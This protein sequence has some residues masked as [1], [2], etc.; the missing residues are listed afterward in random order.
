MI[1]NTLLALLLALTL[2]AGQVRTVLYNKPAQTAVSC[3]GTD[4]TLGTYTI[5][6][7]TMS[8][9][10]TLDVVATARKVTGPAIPTVRLWFGA[11]YG[12]GATATTGIASNA[13][14]LG[15]QD[16]AQTWV[17]AT[18]GNRSTVGSST[19][20]SPAPKEA[21]SGNIVT[22]LV[23]DGGSCA[24]GSTVQ[25]AR[26]SVIDVRNTGVNAPPADF[27]L[28]SIPVNIAAQPGGMGSYVVTVAPLN[29]FTATATL[30][31]TGWPATTSYSFTPTTITGGSGSSTLAFTVPGGASPG[32]YPIT[33]TATSGA[34]VHV[35]N[36]VLNLFVP[37]TPDFTISLFPT[38]PTRRLFDAITVASGGTAS[39]TA[40]ALSANGFAGTITMSQSGLPSGAGSITWTPATITGGSGTSVLTF[41]V[42]STPATYTIHGTGTAGALVHADTSTLVVTASTVTVPN[43]VNTTQAAADTAITGLGLVSSHLYTFPSSTIVAGNIIS[44]DPLA[45]IAVAPGSTV[46]I[47]TSSGAPLTSALPAF[48][49]ATGGGA[50]SVGGRAGLVIE[51]TNL[52]DSGTGSLRACIEASGPRTCIPRVGGLITL[53]SVITISNPYITI[54]GQTAPGSGLTIR[55]ADGST[56]NCL[57]LYTHDV[58]I[59]YIRVRPGRGAV[60][61]RA[62]GGIFALGNAYNVVIDHV[63]T[64]WSAYDMMGTWSNNGIQHDMTWSEN[65]MSEGLA[66]SPIYHAKAFNTGSD[67]QA[68][69]AQMVNI[70]LHHNLMSTNENRAPL[71]RNA[72]ARLVNNIV[73]NNVYGDMTPAGGIAVDII[74]NKIKR[75]PDYDGYDRHEVGWEITGEPDAQPGNPSIYISGNLGPHNTTNLVD[76]NWASMM[77]VIQAGDYHSDSGPVNRAYQRLTP[78]ATQTFPILID[79]ASA[80]DALLTAAGRFGVGASARLNNDG[81]WTANR[82]TVDARILTEYLAGTGGSVPPPDEASVGGYPSYSAGTALVD[83]D[84]DGCPDAWETAH[85]RNPAVYDSNE[86]DPVTGFTWLE[87]F[88]DGLL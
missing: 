60:N 25:L 77:N 41:T 15:I 73:Y 68:N 10:D 8:A 11:A 83:T 51:V 86:T 3:D 45:G 37:A 29:G 47:V 7:G 50:A 49:E 52:N 78:L 71:M 9:G 81:T 70:D 31:A 35:T 80:L 76:D 62:R 20:T 17:V 48:P 88:L 4:K 36:L 66:F 12:P 14:E 55:M 32:T 56:D 57:N 5:S 13:A 69:G 87:D 42:G 44:Q 58:I 27:T 61:I 22:K 43:V 82:D 26:M 28:T 64:S 54:A 63:S 6:G 79:A 75:G 23:M 33:V 2:Q 84:H 39:F 65:I 19:D 16:N 67:F 24:T 85:G 72:S 53:S 38:T 59:R 21:I 18:E 1:R 34:I 30:T 46:G 74:S 40:T